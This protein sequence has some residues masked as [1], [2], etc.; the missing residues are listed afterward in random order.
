MP[1]LCFLLE[2]GNEVALRFLFLF[3]YCLVHIR[4]EVFS[5]IFLLADIS[6]VICIDTGFLVCC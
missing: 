5:V 3:G 1:V 4:V 6:D 2:V